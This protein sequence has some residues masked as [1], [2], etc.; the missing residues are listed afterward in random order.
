MMMDRSLLTLTA[1]RIAE[2]AHTHNLGAVRVVL[3]GGE[4]LLAGYSYLANMV[5]QL[6][7]TIEPVT[8]VQ[9]GM[10]TNAILIDE[11][12]LQMFRSF[13]VHVGV[14]VDGDRTA[15]NRHRRYAGG[16][17]SHDAVAKGLRLLMRPENREIYSGLLCTIDLRNDPIAVYE[18]VLEFEP[19]AVD[20]LLPHGTWSTPPPGRDR[21]A[22]HAPYAEWLIAIFDRWYGSPRKETRVRLF[23]ETIHLLLGGKSATETVGLTP[24]SLIVVETDGGIEQADALKAA[25]KGAPGTGLHITRDSFDAA[26]ILPSI[27]ARQLGID[28]LADKCRVCSIR[29]ICGGGLYAHR[30]RLGNGFRN[31]SVYCP[32]LFRLIQHIRAR[33]AADISTEVATAR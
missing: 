30:Y 13:S 22:M 27:A 24:T 7:K 21:D 10:Q 14:S 31:P 26:L 12:F 18:A 8:R 9:I 17:G 6:R 4:P 32:D 28:A 15:N 33:V 2:H 3:H 11:D 29:R 16:Y 1:Q 20:F 23:E 19:P 5:H 25:Y